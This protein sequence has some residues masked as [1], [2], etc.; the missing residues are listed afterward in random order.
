MLRMFGGLFSA[1]SLVLL[2]LGVKLVAVFAVL[3]LAFILF[4]IDSA[5]NG[6]VRIR[7]GGEDDEMPL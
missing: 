7:K 6:G 3:A 5:M 2:F 4:G 1:F